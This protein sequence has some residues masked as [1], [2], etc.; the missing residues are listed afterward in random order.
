MT[1]LHT[2]RRSV[3]A[4][5]AAA[6]LATLGAAGHSA[7]AAAEPEAKPG[8]QRLSL[9]Q[10]RKWEALGYGMFIHFGMSTYDGDELSQGD[11]PASLYNPT[12]L[13]VNQWV[14]VARDAGM[15]YV[16]LT[17]KHVAGH[18]LWPSKHTAY[19]VANS[20]NKTDVIEAFVT[21][22]DQRGVMPGFYYC[23]WDNH[24]RFGSVT[25]RSPGVDWR[26]WPSARYNFRSPTAT[27]PANPAEPLP[28]FTTSV[29]QGFMTAQI[30][31]LLT[32]Y[33]A[34]GEMWIDIPGVLGMGY[35]TF[36]YE[37]MARLQPQTVLMMNSGM[38]NQAEY[39]VEYAWPADIIAIERHVPPPGGHRKWRTIEGREYYLPG[40]V[41]DTIGQQWFFVPG[42]APRPTE[43]LVHLFK[44]SR[45]G[46][47][48]LLLDVPPDQRGLIPDEHVKALMELR[49]AV[50]L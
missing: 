34:I 18:C 9:E 13:D 16:V 49:R 36:L 44:A 41:C 20:G 43:E 39:D 5:A 33:G 8:R 30:R 6:G 37:E 17:A 7:Q 2:S 25:P 28:A 22:C 12:A 1:Q 45:E 35:R 50:G 23:S 3:L 38:S 26:N 10:L 14:S 11:K 24:N 29:Y 4:G 19:T 32:Q 46:G 42:D 40:E 48:N 27:A 15:K 31:E 47:A 21:A